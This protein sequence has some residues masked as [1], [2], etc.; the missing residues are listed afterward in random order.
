MAVKRKGYVCYRLHLGE[1]PFRAP[2]LHV[3][4]RILLSQ[5]AT[6][7]ILY[8]SMTMHIYIYIFMYICCFL[9]NG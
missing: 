5:K 1:D 4:S 9:V 6:G 7:K 2:T 3:F 8:I